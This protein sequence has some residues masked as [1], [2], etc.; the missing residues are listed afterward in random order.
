MVLKGSE[1][2]EYCLLGSDA[3]LFGVQVP[4]FRINTLDPKR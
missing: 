2:S 4:I 3:V 1:E